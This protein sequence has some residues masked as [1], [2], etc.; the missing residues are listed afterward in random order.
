M[1]FAGGAADHECLHG[2]K[3]RELSPDSIDHF[4]DWAGDS[5]GQVLADEK[6]RL[7]TAHPLLLVFQDEKKIIER[8]GQR[9]ADELV[10][11]VVLALVAK[12]LT[13]GR[14]ALEIRLSN[15]GCKALRNPEAMSGSLANEPP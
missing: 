5:L 15:D 3:T 7:D 9:G 11:A 6:E 12:G 4:T 2:E 8:F 10:K 14:A 13:P 1:P